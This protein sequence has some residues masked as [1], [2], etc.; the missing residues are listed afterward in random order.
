MMLLVFA[1]TPP[2]PGAE[3]NADPRTVFFSS[4]RRHTRLQGD[5]SSD[6]CSSDLMSQGEAVLGHTAAINGIFR[7]TVWGDFKIGR[8]SC[9][10]RVEIWVVAVGVQKQRQIVQARER[11]VKESAA[12]RLRRC[13]AHV[14]DLSR[15]PL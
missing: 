1:A 7:L 13:S 4:R 5:W 11:P 8:A 2:R 12:G 9:R 6:V 15:A 14:D 3:S 10:E